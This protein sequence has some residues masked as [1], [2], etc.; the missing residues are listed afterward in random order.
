MQHITISFLTCFVYMSEEDVVVV[1]VV[2]VV[3]VVINM[4]VV[5]T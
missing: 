4:A 1:V 5:N 3:T 2:V